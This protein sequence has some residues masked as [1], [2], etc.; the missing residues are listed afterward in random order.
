MS[1][2]CEHA[3]DASEREWTRRSGLER[4]T[5]GVEILGAARAR[6]EANCLELALFTATQSETRAEDLVDDDRAVRLLQ[7]FDED[8]KLVTTG[9]V[10]AHVDAI[11]E[12]IGKRPREL[13]AGGRRKDSNAALVE[14]VVQT[15]LNDAR[16]GQGVDQLGWR[17][18]SAADSAEVVGSS[19]ARG[20]VKRSSTK[21]TLFAGRK[22]QMA[23]KQNRPRR[24]SLVYA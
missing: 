11:L 23:A 3:A 19:P 7:P 8:V 6:V 13:V 21:K 5:A 22:S 2:A 12:D 16:N 4:S 9:K 18:E 1:A 17:L 14:R 10:A 15:G 20:T 24:N